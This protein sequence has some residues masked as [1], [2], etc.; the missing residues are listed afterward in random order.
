MEKSADYFTVTLQKG[1]LSGEQLLIEPVQT[2]DGVSIYNCLLDGKPI[3]QLRQSSDGDWIQVW[4]TLDKHSVLAIG[5][6]LE[7]HLQ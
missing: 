7:H 5:E 3:T 1:T 4:G 2:T 6:A